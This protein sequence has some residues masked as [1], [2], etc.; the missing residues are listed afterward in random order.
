[1]NRVILRPA[2]P[3]DITTEQA[4]E[5]ARAIRQK[6]PSYDVIVEPKEQEEGRYGLTWFEVL[7]ISLIAG[8]GIA[9]TTAV[10]ELTKMCINWARERFK[11]KGQSRRPTYIAIY[12]PDNEL[13]MSVVVKNATDEPEDRTEADRKRAEAAKPKGD[14]K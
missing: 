11:K 3:H 9:L 14:N 7:R 2:N 4:E 6:Y 13:L 10:Q 5:L 8:L 1:M 12:G